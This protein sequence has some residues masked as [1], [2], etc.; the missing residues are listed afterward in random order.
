MKLNEKEVKQ[1]AKDKELLI[2]P[3]S[4]KIYV[5][6]SQELRDDENLVYFCAAKNIKE[7]GTLMLTNKRLCFIK[8]GFF[9]NS[10]LSIDLD[11]IN[12]VTKRNGLLSNELEVYDNSGKIVYDVTTVIDKLE[13]AII[14]EK[15]KFSKLC[16]TTTTL[17]STDEILKYK[18]LLDEGILTKE[19]FEKKK[20]ELLGF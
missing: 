2:P 16:D 18:K 15:N 12:S 10:V 4:K 19:E 3:F 17:S 14:N 9:G 5:S 7:N 6:V 1:F 11:K 8:F 13:S 20:K